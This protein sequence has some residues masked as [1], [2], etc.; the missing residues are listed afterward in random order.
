VLV[1]SDTVTFRHHTLEILILLTEDR[2]IHFLQALVKAVR[3]DKSLDS[4]N[5]KNAGHRKLVGNI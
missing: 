5:K 4:T 2:V 1:E 3:A